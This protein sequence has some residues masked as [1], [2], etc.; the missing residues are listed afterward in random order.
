L[1]QWPRDK[2]RPNCQFQ[3]V[4]SKRIQAQ[5]AEKNN[6]LS[7]EAQLKQANAL[8]SL[9]EDR[10]KTKVRCVFSFELKEVKLTGTFPSIVSLAH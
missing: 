10:Y 6:V 2:L 9:L 3:D 1:A 8:Y 7:E 5:L 4:L